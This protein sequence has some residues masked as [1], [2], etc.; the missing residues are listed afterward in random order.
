L[1]N[2][3]PDD[4]EEEDSDEEE[5]D[6][7][8]EEEPDEE[9]GKSS[10]AKER[11]SLQARYDDIV[12]DCRNHMNLLMLRP[13]ATH[14]EWIRDAFTNSIDDIA[15]VESAAKK[16]AKL[17]DETNVRQCTLEKGG[18]QF[19]SQLLTEPV[20]AVVT[21]GQQKKA[22]IPTAGGKKK[23]EGPTPEQVDSVY[24]YM[25]E[26][27]LEGIICGAEETFVRTDEAL[28]EEV[29]VQ[30][31]MAGYD[32]ITS[33]ATLRR[34]DFDE[35]GYLGSVAFVHIDDKVFRDELMQ[36]SFEWANVARFK[37]LAGVREVVEYG[38]RAVVIIYEN[39][40]LRHGNF[41]N[42]NKTIYACLGE[43]LNMDFKIVDSIAH[44][45][46][47]LGDLISIQDYTTSPCPIF[48]MQNL[49]NP[50][51]V[52]LAQTIIPEDDADTE[53]IPIGLEEHFAVTYR[54]MA[55]ETVMV[56]VGEI[57]VPCSPNPT[58]AL[59]DVFAFALERYGAIWLD[60]SDTSLF[61][62]EDS[63]L[64]ATA[65]INQHRYVS[66]DV[67][68][69]LIWSAVLLDMP[70]YAGIFKHIS[71]GGGITDLP[72]EKLR[73]VNHMA[74]LF[75]NQI[76]PTLLA[77]VGGRL[78]QDKFQLLDRLIDLVRSI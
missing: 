4:S 14:A 57:D 72:S 23:V 21:K 33:C 26:K 18:L 69:T 28:Q 52:P 20:A 50:K 42:I 71:T 13:L 22:A 40:F 31:H 68:E 34:D 53:I 74:D 38:A 66:M 45:K 48:M 5:E 24:K 60:A 39:T 73:L 46:V 64:T 11:H 76:N 6:E 35:G 55:I 43:Y 63:V 56:H 19:W 3:D 70:Y 12:Y 49:A 1:A 41:E 36:S 75:P 7:E 30:T 16:A 61:V 51:I 67:R 2:R 65:C 10:V 78:R 54:R 9:D 47:L 44:L 32:S 15:D 58:T 59:Q 27:I 8:N 62:P 37:M 17:S 77:V 25:A 29:R